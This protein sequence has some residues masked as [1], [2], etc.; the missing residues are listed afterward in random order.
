MNRCLIARQVREL[1]A[2]LS[3]NKSELSR[4]LGVSRP[5]VY[6]WLDDGEPNA[7]NRARIRTLMRLLAE[8]GVS[9]DNP[10]FPR[11]VRSALEPG[12]QIL[13]DVLSEE[14]IDEVTAKDLI[15]R[16]K[17]VGDAMALMDWPGG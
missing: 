11:F 12:N 6:D 3:I 14:T 7:D 8:S 5:T 16:A 13:L 1:Q 4:I 17:A 10:L 15:R 2:A 9:A